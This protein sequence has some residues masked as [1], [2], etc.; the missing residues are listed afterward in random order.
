MY[1]IGQTAEKLGIK[2]STLRYYEKEG[3][4]SHV[5]RKP[6]GIR[7]F[8]E[9][10]MKELEEILFLKQL[11]MSVGKMKVYLQLCHSGDETMNQRLA[12]LH[13]LKQD[14]LRRIAELDHAVVQIDEMISRNFTLIEERQKAV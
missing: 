10:D 2:V 9:E 14:V 5:N 11:D 8:S 13:N 6:S 1:T 3:L 12:V 7:I 4:L